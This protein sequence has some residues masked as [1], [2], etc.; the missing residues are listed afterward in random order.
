[1]DAA[2]TIATI[3]FILSMINERIANFIKL[4]FSNKSILGIAL[5]NLRVKSANE[6]DEDERSKRILVLN[7]VSGTVVALILHADLIEILGHIDKP[8]DV[9]GWDKTLPTRFGWVLL[10]IGCFL[11]GCFISLGSKFWHD[12]LDLLLYAGKFNQ[13]K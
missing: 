2:V 7:I 12:L 13:A 3:L 4:Q 6:Y 1:M 8:Y 11:T 5:G 10:P 9:I